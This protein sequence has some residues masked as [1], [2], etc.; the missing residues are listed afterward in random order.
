MKS[1]RLIRPIQSGNLIAFL[2]MTDLR[3]IT[4]AVPLCHAQRLLVGIIVNLP[5]VGSVIIAHDCI[6][7]IAY[8]RLTSIP[9]SI[10]LFR[11]LLATSLSLR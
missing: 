11:Y 3:I 10:S 7:I 1:Q 9:G 8:R 2:I 6:I 5:H 4:L